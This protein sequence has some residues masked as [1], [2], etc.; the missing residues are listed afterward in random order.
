[1][2]GIAGIGATDP[3]T[4]IQTALRMMSAQIEHRGPDASGYWV[5][6]IARV[7]FAHRRLSIL[8][9]SASGNQPMISTSK[10]FIVCFNGEIYNFKD[11]RQELELKQFQFRGHSDTEVL[12]AAIECW[13]LEK[14]VSRFVGMFAF[15]LW[16][17]QKR[18]VYLVRD[19]VGKKPLYY[20][21]NGL[22]WAFASELKALSTLD[23]FQFS[24]S[25]EATSL[26]VRYGYI[27]APLSIYENV[28]KVE[29]GTIVELTNQ[30]RCN[31]VRYWD[32]NSV[33]LEGLR[34]PLRTSAGDIYEELEQLLAD[35]V[36]LRMI[37]DVPLGAFLSGGIDSSTIVALMRQFSSSTVKTYTIGF[38]EQAFNEAGYA[39][40]V[41]KYFGTEHHEFFVSQHDMLSKVDH[42]AH[43]IDE[44][45]S[46]ISI[47]PT[48][49]VS[50]LAAQHV[51]V[52]LSGDGGDELFCGYSHYERINTTAHYRHRIP[53]S[54]AKFL[55]RLLIGTNSSAGKIA[56]LGGILCAETD[57]A[58]C[59]AVLSQ[60]QIPST[61]VRNGN[62]GDSRISIPAD[63]IL[64]NDI[65]NYAMARDMQRY[66]VD[67]I[68]HKVDR[69]S[70]AASIEA[71]APLLDHRILEFAWRIPLNLKYADGVSKKPLRAILDKY[72]PTHFYNR[73]KKGFGVPISSWLRGELLDWA[74][75]LISDSANNGYF[76]QRCVQRMWDQ[77]QSKRYDRGSYL[78][79]ILLFLHW[80]KQCGK[81]R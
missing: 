43:V 50:E 62:D 44:P 40:E 17:E 15:A 37:S 51:K 52:V 39:R 80:T 78:W 81:G 41:A 54:V 38:E 18:S 29:P 42:I 79:S 35:A 58:L 74:H 32:V 1:M 30:G 75:S 65:R 59:R 7:G 24:I 31:I 27:P 45:M 26:Y 16:D 67:D 20:I 10:Q 64:H 19:R 77:H 2:C 61:I 25:T 76:D 33:A 73:P 48:L 71:R 70:M 23:Q 28:C 49:A 47:L 53:N 14:A 8:D 57:D 56:R 36:R 69:A 5:N 13:G 4:D 55:G 63:A 72:L 9:L 46:D 6:P 22:N 68:L 3:Q 12:L 11:L 21:H 34:H 66:M 60:W